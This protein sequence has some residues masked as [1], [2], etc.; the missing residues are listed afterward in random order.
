MRYSRQSIGKDKCSKRIRVMVSRYGSFL[1]AKCP[2]LG[3]R[4]PRDLP[5]TQVTTPGYLRF[6][7][8]VTM[9]NYCHGLTAC[10]RYTS[11]EAKISV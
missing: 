8:H 11:A 2:R 9:Q 5:R 7:K 3:N 10:G 4:G 6:K 1:C